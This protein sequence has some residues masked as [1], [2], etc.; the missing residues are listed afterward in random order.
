MK[1]VAITP[2][3]MK[4]AD[5]QHPAAVKDPGNFMQFLQQFSQNL[6][7]NLAN[8]E[9]IL[10]QEE[11]SCGEQENQLADD[12]KDGS[13]ADS[14]NVTDSV[15]PE[16]NSE[17]TKQAE[18]VNEG[19]VGWLDFFGSQM[20]ESK[21][22]FLGGHP[23]QLPKEAQLVVDSAN[24]QPAPSVTTDQVYQSTGGSQLTD[25]AFEQTLSKSGT[26]AAA[27]LPTGELTADGETTR[28]DSGTESM[29]QTDS[30]ADT[31]A[32]TKVNTNN[33]TTLFG[34]EP[35][36]KDAQDVI[37]QH[38]L[39]RVAI[40]ESPKIDESM[41][42]IDG[43]NGLQ[44]TATLDFSNLLMQNDQRATPAAVK[45][46]IEPL[47]QKIEQLVQTPEKKITLQLV[48]EKLGK[49]RI[50]LEVTAQGSR[51]EFTVEQQQTK[52]LLSSIKSELEQVL[53]KQEN[54]LLSGKEGILKETSTTAIDRAALTGSLTNFTSTADGQAAQ[55]GF[56]QP[57]RQSGKK[58]YNQV[59]LPKEE[60]TTEQTNHAISILA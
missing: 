59:P 21:G 7:G 55:Q 23:L 49:V 40:S 14:E 37:P 10:S 53:Q 24:E 9:G 19:A 16:A 3:L 11:L 27:I 31:K 20:T 25:T 8:E 47:T 44:P 18:I 36:K 48:P 51:L 32:D 17:L 6:E 34:G 43:T 42:P 50:A 28:L 1:Q 52:H 45:T 54:Q 39:E 29:S 5:K 22:D 60:E 58:I 38:I 57:Q 35:S 56:S 4:A 26:P 46:V 12:K 41:K 15:I 30:P 13:V 33:E 2:A